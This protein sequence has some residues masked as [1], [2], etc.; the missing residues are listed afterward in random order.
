MNNELEPRMT[1]PAL[2][3][4]MGDWIYYITYMRFI[5]IRYWIK[6]T[7]EIHPNKS[8]R[9]MIQR[10]LTNR[11]SN[12]ADYLINQ[13][14]MFFNSIVIGVYGG[15]PQ[16]Y[17][18]EISES[19]TLG[20][21]DLD[22]DSRNA[23]GLLMFEGNE[24]LFA[25]DGQHRVAG[26]KLALE[27]KSDLGNEEQ[28]VI[29]VAHK[30]DAPGRERTR[31]LFTTLNKHAKKVSKTDIIALDEDDAFAVVTRRL[32]EDF[33]LLNSGFVDV[34]S[35]QTSVPPTDRRSL[36]TIVT[37]Y[38]IV[39]TTY[40]ISLT[41]AIKKRLIY[42]RP[43]DKV[44]EEIYQEQ[45]DYWTLMKEN[46]PEYAEFFN[47]GLE[48]E[49][50]GK[51]RTSEGGHLLFRPLGQVAFS[52]AVRVIRNRG[53]SMEKA[54]EALSKVPMDLNSP[55]WQY[56]LWHPGLKQ[57]NNKVSRLLLESLL[58]YQVGHPPRQSK[59][60]LLNEY[61]KVLDDPKV[62]LPPVVHSLTFIK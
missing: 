61:R 52:K 42:F 27:R 47:S 36:T 41:K 60:Q 40:A 23:I 37:L 8:L 54:I 22:E 46:I 11:S 26:I 29:F 14:E 12:I 39:A 10:K 57:I 32:V 33:T 50:A 31:R 16:W 49:I 4:N 38:D 9:E 35:K 15:A 34:D 53:Q 7:A 25:I 56:V 59:Y 58:L 45:V 13:K 28:S 51:Y 5:D 21:P 24:K 30:T 2:R 55:P 17:P 44:L 43:S 62:E 19:P 6:P 20:E 3:C 1:Y 18:L 48:D